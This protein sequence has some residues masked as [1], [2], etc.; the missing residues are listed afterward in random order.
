MDICCLIPKE[1]EILV[2]LRYLSISSGARHVIPAD[3]ICNLG[4]LETLDMRNSKIECLPKGISKL[5][6]LR[7]LYL[8][9]PTSLP[10][11][12]DK[13]TLPNLQV[14]TGIV[15]NHDTE[16]LFA[17]ARFPN[18]RKL[19]LRSLNVAQ[20]GLFTLSLSSI[21]P[22]RHLQTLKICKCIN[23]TNP[24]SL[25]LTLTKVTLQDVLDVSPSIR[26]LGCLINLR[27]LKV[28]G[29][30]SF[31]LD[32]DETSFCQLRV[33][34]MAKL[35]VLQWTMKNGAMPRL[36]RLI[37]ERCNFFKMPPDE[38]W[39]LSA[40]RDVEVLHP[41]QDLANMLRNLQMR[42]GCELQVYPPL[43][44]SLP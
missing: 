9:G 20:S 22:L 41:D 43:N 14:I 15:L 27:I 32:C 1:I 34:K 19:G 11:A 39:C 21:H 13:A 24:S 37:I 25:Q 35:T 36:Q 2:L 33:L 42:D 31:A 8:D 5:Q 44:S 3:S 28:N 12:D 10:R 29:C 40:L 6:K 38:L 18:Q 4:N 17:K 7:H 16:S 26:V 23:L 30:S